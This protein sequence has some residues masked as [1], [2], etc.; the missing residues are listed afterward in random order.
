MWSK[1]ETHFLST[2]IDA[3]LEEESA[4]LSAREMFLGTER[5][6]K[7]S[8]SQPQVSLQANNGGSSRGQVLRG[9]GRG[10]GFIARVESQGLMYPGRGG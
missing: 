6:W 7:L 5:L 1:G 9:S 10:P 8:K 3:D 2:C 4:I